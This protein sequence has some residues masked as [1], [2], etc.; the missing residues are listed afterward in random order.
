LA[1]AGYSRAVVGNADGLELPPNTASESSDT[2]DELSQRFRRDGVAGLMDADGR[3]P[4]GSV[5]K[6]LLED[7]PEAAFG[8][9]LDVDAV[10][11]AFAD[12]WRSKS[13]V[14]V[15]ASDL[16]RADIYREVVASDRRGAV[17]THAL[18]ATD[19]LVGRLLKSVDPAR[20]AV[21]VVGPAASAS[22]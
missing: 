6:A 17:F 3:V 15:E 18:R 16:V 8:V 22:G 2:S 14:L 1:R 9:R 19:R 7:D 13:V 10:N 5:S 4:A 20:D 11:A 12:V 21:V